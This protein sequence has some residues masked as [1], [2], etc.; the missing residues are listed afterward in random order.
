MGKKHKDKKH[1]DRV[2]NLKIAPKR[3]L[4]VTPTSV[5]TLVG[6]LVAL[7]IFWPRVTVEFTD[8]VDPANPLSSKVTITNATFIA[9]LESVTV[10]LGLCQ[11]A[12]DPLEIDPH[13]PCNT[14]K[15]A[16]FVQPS[17]T[18]HYLAA[19]EAYGISFGD[20]FAPPPNGRISG[21]DVSAIVIYHWWFIP[22]ECRTTR[23]FVTRKQEDGKLHWFPQPLDESSR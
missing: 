19:D 8:P 2:S 3:T 23:R 20:I 11:L 10:A 21:A 13:L 4:R 5:I 15:V 16:S 12:T 7:L 22:F 17:W 14:S 9:P 1:S 6:F 18:H